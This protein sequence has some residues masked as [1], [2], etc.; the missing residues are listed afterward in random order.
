MLCNCILYWLGGFIYYIIIEEF[1]IKNIEFIVFW[2]SW[3]MIIDLWFGLRFYCMIS[4][5]FFL[6]NMYV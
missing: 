6:W 3:K 5:M 2:C 4:K 1:V